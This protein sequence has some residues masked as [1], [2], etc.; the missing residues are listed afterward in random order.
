MAR[1]LYVLSLALS[2]L[3][4]PAHKLQARQVTTLKAAAGARYFGAALATP[5][6]QNQSD[7]HFSALG[8]SQFS[9]ATPENE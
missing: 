5:H 7:P 1:F 2:A 6:L 4:S 8:A 3:A 9:G